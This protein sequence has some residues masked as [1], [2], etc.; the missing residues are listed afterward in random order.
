MHYRQVFYCF[1]LFIILFELACCKSFNLDDSALNAEHKPLA[2][3]TSEEDTPSHDE[4]S[5]PP[6][7]SVR[8]KP[9]IISFNIMVA[10][11]SGLGK[12][13][14]CEVLLNSWKE[15][16]TTDKKKASRTKR[17][18]SPTTLA[19]KASP[20]MEW[21]DIS[22]NTII[23]VKIVDTPGF[24]NKI[25]HKNSAEIIMEYI[26]SCRLKK[27]RNEQ[28]S[29]PQTEDNSLIHVCLYFLSPG[30]FLEIDRMFLCNIQ[31]EIPIVPIIAKA[32]T[33]TD[34]EISHY[35]AML[36]KTFEKEGIRI[37][38]SFDDDNSLTKNKYNRGRRK[39][40]AFAI[41]G[42]DGK[43]P[44]GEARSFDPNHSDLKLI[45]DLLLSDHTEKF[46]DKSQATYLNYRA[47]RIL[48][49]KVLGGLKYAA[50]VGLLAVQL[51][52]TLNVHSENQSLQSLKS[53]TKN[54]VAK[55][56]GLFAVLKKTKES[57]QLLS[58]SKS[59]AEDEGEDSKDVEESELTFSTSKLPLFLRRSVK[60]RG[61][62]CT[63]PY[64]DC[65]GSH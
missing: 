18:I 47:K 28:S 25:N 31:K 52:A 41:I 44:W 49:N 17:K 10:G 55:L 19:V 22:A 59:I 30:R 23:R 13:T 60:Q 8:L 50:L 1:L 33:L 27:F 63:P 42:R 5:L 24:G 51:S 56:G 45:R 38:D 65:F 12:T 46:I 11:L 14:L 40:E 35:R 53:T 32:D 43:Y 26:Q 48:R 61:L 15:T 16:P 37:Y 58:E 4:S 2:S 54:L 62:F 64:K 34:E 9:R 7:D 21:H 3:L 57:P 20:A 36:K 39:G 29:N 6:P